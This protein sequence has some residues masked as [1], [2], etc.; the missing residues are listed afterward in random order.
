[1]GLR[2]SEY[3]LCGEDG[4]HGSERARPGREAVII[5]MQLFFERQISVCP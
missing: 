3:V 4:P 2:R 5:L 1:M